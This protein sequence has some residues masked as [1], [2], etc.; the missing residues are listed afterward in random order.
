MN[1][2]LRQGFIQLISQRTGLCIR[3]QEQEALDKKIEM[4][5]KVLKL[6]CAEEYLRLLSVQTEQSDRE[7]KKLLLVLTTCETYFFRDSGQFRLLQ[8]KVLPQL[9]NAKREESAAQGSKPT[10]RFWSAGCST[11]EEAYSL[12]IL[13]TELLPDYDEWNLYILGTD[14]NQEVLEKAKRGIYNSWSFR[15]IEPDLQSQYFHQS[16]DEWELDKKIRQ[17]VTFSEGNLIA[18]SFPNSNICNMDL[19]LCRNVFVY[20]DFKSIATV[21]DKFYDVLKPE[22]YLLTGHTEL[23]GQNL[24]RFQVHVL[25]ESVLYQRREGAATA[26]ASSVPKQQVLHFTPTQ[27]DPA[28]ATQE[29]AKF[30]PTLPTFNTHHSTKKIVKSNSGHIPDLDAVATAKK[31]KKKSRNLLVSNPTLK[32]AEILFRQK[33]YCESIQKAK[34]AIK[35]HSD[36]FESYYLIAQAYANLGN[37]KQAEFYCYQAI[38]INSF[39]V[40]PYY[41]LAQIAQEEGDLEAAKSLLK[42]IIYLAP[43]SIFAYFEL[44]SLYERTGDYNR[45]KKMFSTAFE[46]LKA[47]PPSTT[48]EPQREVKAGDLLVHVQKLLLNYR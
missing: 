36:L 3:R 14:I 37:H 7:W 16:K 42:K 15:I 8:N 32:E 28:I 9:I 43:S 10:L 20:F 18:D 21:I 41:L 46:F 11:G 13:L 5:I 17:M 12:A 39:S 27:I 40:L 47:L 24:S 30:V 22:G 35:S 45:A 1:D 48:I 23:Y 6:S 25:P 4:R 38:N 26:I 19:I 2:A 29:I 33:A 34:Q 44:G 31:I